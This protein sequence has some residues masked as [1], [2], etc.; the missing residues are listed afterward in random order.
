ML[1]NSIIEGSLG[2]RHLGV[3][4]TAG[5]I[6]PK[7]D[8]YN[9]CKCLRTGEIQCS[10]K[11]CHPGKYECSRLYIFDSPCARYCLH[12]KPSVSTPLTLSKNVSTSIF[13]NRLSLVSQHSTTNSIS[14]LMSRLIDIKKSMVSN[15]F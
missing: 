7:G 2:C 14:Y 12:S 11:K 5:D 1:T 13:Q 8:D 15:L 9:T 3:T 4:Y 10:E 6:F